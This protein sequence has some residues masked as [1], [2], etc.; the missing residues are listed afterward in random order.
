MSAAAPSLSGGARARR[1][2]LPLGRVPA[3][4]ITACAGVAYVLA[5]PPSADLAAAAYRSDLFA[6]AGFTIWDNGWYGGHHLPAYSLLAP[7]LGAW[8]GPQVV[9]ALSMT[10]AAA[11]FAALIE[12]AFTARATRLA[13]L[14]LAVG[15]AVS[16]LS[17]RVPFD[18][19]LAIG[20]GAL[21][22][23]RRGSR[24][25]ALALAVTCALASPVAGAFLALA[26]VAW[27][28]AYRRRWAFV[29][30]ICALAPIG[31]LAYAFPE[32]GSQPFA[33]S[34]FYPGLLGVAIIAAFTPSTPRATLALRIGAAL[35]GLMLIGAYA[36]PTAVGSNAD[37]LG[38]LFAG[39]VAACAL[40]ERPPRWL[41][42]ALAP[43]LL[44]WQVNTP[45]S[46]LVTGITDPA[47]SA[48]YYAPLLGELRTLGVGYGGPP[49]RPARIEAVPDTEHWEARWLAPHVAL[50]RGWERQLD[51]SRNNLFYDGRPLT[52][53]RY[54]GWLSE[55]AISYVALP[56]GPLDYS[57]SEEARLLLGGARAGQAAHPPSYLHEVWRSAH[58]RLFAVAGAQPL[59]RAPATMTQL[60]PES[61]TVAAPRAGRYLTRV[62]FTPYWKV[63]GG[64]GCVAEAPGGWTYVTATRAERVAVR[65]GFS[66]ERV[67]SRGARCD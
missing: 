53:G 34:A 4:A 52:A 14:W 65:I 63:S 30:A 7:A 55:Q 47:T 11:L 2:S 40:L 62:R 59:A 67:F 29:V 3:W 36:L 22:A 58:W 16:L 6:R 19:G 64:S 20:L 39:P 26:C 60:G 15:A 48:S 25:G 33:S 54:R 50:A 24:W 32:G 57:A 56:D 18:L 51:Q 31:A 27:G 44:Y 9:A 45:V 5:A 1:R 38:A 49:T 35:Y 37:R 66:L 23:A 46:D 13:A 43:F 28:L 17:N 41:F 61:F 42:L 8:L 10:A 21:V 12:G